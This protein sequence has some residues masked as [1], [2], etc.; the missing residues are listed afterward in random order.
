MYPTFELEKFYWGQGK[1][2]VLG[3]DEVGRGALAGPFVVAGALFL[4]EDWV[5]GVRD[6]KLISE[7]KRED[8]AED[9]TESVVYEIVEVSHAD[10]DQMGLTKAFNY[11]LREIVKK[12]GCDVVVIDGNRMRGYGDKF[13][14]QKKADRDV[15]SVAAASVLAKVYRDNLMID[16]ATTYPEYGFEKHKGYASEE[17]RNSIMQFGQCEI[18]RKSFN[19][20][21]L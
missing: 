14:F 2:R 18:H 6:S 7:K 12:I 17:H 20:S 9:L 10:V 21:F 19:L 15:M 4:E 8:V 13:H 16:Y 5:D 3:V 11:A 1:T